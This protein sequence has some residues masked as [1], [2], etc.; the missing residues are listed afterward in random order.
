VEIAY[1]FFFLLTAVWSTSIAVARNVDI[2]IH[3]VAK[4]V[5][6]TVKKASDAWG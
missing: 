1:R 2:E 3:C 5:D 6:Q 4:R